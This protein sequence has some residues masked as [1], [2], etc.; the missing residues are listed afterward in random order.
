MPTQTAPAEDV[1]RIA[2]TPSSKVGDE[3]NAEGQNQLLAESDA[4]RP[5]LV[6]SAWQIGLAVVA[7]ISVLLMF[8]MRRLAIIRWSK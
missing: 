8:A 1:A 7:I 6:S 3:A 4:I 5:A 2:E